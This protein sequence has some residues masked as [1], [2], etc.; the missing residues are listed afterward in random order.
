MKWY[1]DLSVGNASVDAQHKKLF[2]IVDQLTDAC[3]Q[4]KGKDEVGKTLNFLLDYTKTHFRDEE[5]LM[6]QYNYPNLMAHKKIHDEFTK[7]VA[8][9]VSDY[10]K[11]GASI[12]VV[13]NILSKTNNW[14]INHILKMDK[15]VGKYIKS[16]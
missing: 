1:D 3:N 10:Q 6:M 5:K 13:L 4:K 2:E 14:L 8:G 9:I 15:E 7:E 12:P 16:K 11:N